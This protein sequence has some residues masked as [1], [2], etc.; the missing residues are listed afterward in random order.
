MK[1]KINTTSFGIEVKK[2]LIELDMTQ[3]EFSKQIGI[4]ENYLTDI[5]KGRRAGTKYRSKI[6]KKLQLKNLDM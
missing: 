4:N 2:K 3:R 1:E 5:L 6:I